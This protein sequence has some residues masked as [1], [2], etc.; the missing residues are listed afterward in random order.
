MRIFT[1]S[2][3]VHAVTIIR[4]ALYKDIRLSGNRVRA[5]RARPDVAGRLARL[6]GMD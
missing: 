3:D 2:I 1:D 4:D 5:L 6:R